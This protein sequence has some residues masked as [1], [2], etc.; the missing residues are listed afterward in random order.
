[1]D[2][3][4]LLIMALVGLVAGFLAG[5]VVKGHG[6]GL[7]GNLI[8][9]VIGAFLAGWLLPTLHISFS[10]VNPLITQIVYAAIGAIV[11]LIIIGFFRRAK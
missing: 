11:L 6:F 7:I 3:Q 5:V 9:G 1:M 10:V 2:M 4:S 8:V